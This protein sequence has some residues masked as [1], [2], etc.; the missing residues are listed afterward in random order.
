MK[1]RDP[2]D[3]TRG[4]DSKEHT[5]LMQDV[6]RTRFGVRPKTVPGEVVDD[7]TQE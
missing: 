4:I 3:D 5:Q 6:P 2:N 1:D 7:G